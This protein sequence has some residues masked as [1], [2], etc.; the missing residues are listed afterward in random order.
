M[1][2]NL[3]LENFDESFLR[4][5]SLI[6]ERKK[7]FSELKKIGIP[8][9]KVENWKYTD[10]NNLTKAIE[11]K[12]GTIN[13]ELSNHE[14]EGIFVK[15]FDYFINNKDQYL[16]PIR[17]LKNEGVVYLNISYAS[18]AKVIEI[19]ESQSKPLIINIS[20]EGVG[21]SLPRLKIDVFPEIEAEIHLIYFG[22]EGFINQLTE[23]NLQ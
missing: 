8:N 13:L 6:D 7:A 12:P 18:E 1:H 16:T 14:L 9:K 10:L 4:L 3:I 20:T 22:G 5:P 15:D 21:F 11:F 23:I 17:T 19:R 2:N